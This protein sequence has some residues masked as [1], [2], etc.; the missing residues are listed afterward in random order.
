MNGPH[1]GRVVLI[2]GAGGGVGRGYA[3]LYVAP[4]RLRYNSSS[5]PWPLSE[6]LVLSY[7]VEGYVE[8]EEDCMRD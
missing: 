2:T 3:L 5:L 8:G 7:H 4:P 1:A 6:S